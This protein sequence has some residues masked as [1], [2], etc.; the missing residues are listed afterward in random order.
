MVATDEQKIDKL[1]KHLIVLVEK[2]ETES[3]TDFAVQLAIDKF[4]FI[5]KSVELKLLYEAFRMN[6]MD[7]SG[8][9]KHYR[10][11]YYRWRKDARWL[12]ARRLK[13]ESKADN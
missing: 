11:L 4:Y 5:Q 13:P 10:Q 12:H 8:I 7:R 9:E 3:K 1:I 2:I 6:R